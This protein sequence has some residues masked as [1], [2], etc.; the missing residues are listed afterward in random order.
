MWDLVRLR[1]STLLN[2]TDEKGMTIEKGNRRFAHIRVTV[3]VSSLF[4][5]TGLE[6]ATVSLVDALSRTYKVRVIV[7]ADT[8][9]TSSPAH[10]GNC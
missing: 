2:G 4:P 3:V 7:I 9:S 10:L 5:L 8:V 6:S 1:T